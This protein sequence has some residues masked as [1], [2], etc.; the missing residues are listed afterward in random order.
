MP[1]RCSHCRF[2]QAPRHARW[3]D[4]SLPH[5]LEAARVGISTIS[6]RACVRFPPSVHTGRDGEPRVAY[7]GTQPDEWCGE[8]VLAPWAEKR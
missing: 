4:N 2:W 8:W 7:P 3:A 6:T 1:E 5:E